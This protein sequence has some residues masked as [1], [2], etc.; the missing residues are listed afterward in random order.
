MRVS[1]MRSGST[2]RRR[3]ASIW[4]AAP[5]S[6]A[7]TR[8]ARS[9]TAP[10]KCST[11]RV[12]ATI[13]PVPLRTTARPA[14]NAMNAAIG[15]R[16]AISILTVPRA[17]SARPGAQAFDKSRPDLEQVAH[18]EQVR[19]I[20][21]GRVDVAIDGDD[22]RRRSHPDLVLDGAADPEREVQLGLDDLPGLADLLAIRDPAGIDCRT[23][24]PD[25][26]AERVCDLPHE[27]EAVRA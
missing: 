13:L 21:D 24:R 23:R 5:P 1:P 20:G 17:R 22:G 3:T 10:R 18:D 16:T 9:L 6:E 25:R 12:R 2:W 19:E 14:A 26:S 7:S 11:S 4:P 8:A 15:N 27:R